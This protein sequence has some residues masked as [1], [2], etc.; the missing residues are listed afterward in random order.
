[1][2][3]ECCAFLARR[4]DVPVGYVGDKALF[5]RRRLSGLVARIMLSALA[6]AELSALAAYA[7]KFDGFAPNTAV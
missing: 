6:S 5:V 7:Q 2:S 4:A 3:G 1:M